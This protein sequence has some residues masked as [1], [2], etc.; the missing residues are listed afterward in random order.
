MAG[1]EDV[2]LPLRSQRAKEPT[3]G[4]Y[5]VRDGKK[6]L[7]E[8]GLNCRFDRFSRMFNANGDH[9]DHNGGKDAN[10]R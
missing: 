3:I 4:K 8:V 1:C 6:S 10:K 5:N 9:S 7:I 2:L